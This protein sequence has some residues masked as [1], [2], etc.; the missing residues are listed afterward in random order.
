MRDKVDE[1]EC[2]P[3]FGP[4]VT[5]VTDQSERETENLLPVCVRR[6]AWLV[7]ANQTLNK[8]K[9][10]ASL[11]VAFIGVRACGAAE[12]ATKSAYLQSTSTRWP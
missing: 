10:A 2:L 6:E 11:R 1:T 8:G 5:V 7:I 12:G 3:V 9:R 4:D